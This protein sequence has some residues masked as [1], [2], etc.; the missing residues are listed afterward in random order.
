V[1][2]A[3]GMTPQAYQP[4]YLDPLGRTVKLTLRKSLIAL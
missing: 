1:R 3:K 4:D 2:D